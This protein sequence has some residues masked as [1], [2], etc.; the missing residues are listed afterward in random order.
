MRH[1]F[2]LI[3]VIFLSSQS[4]HS[5]L[6]INHPYYPDED[7]NQLIGSPDLL[8]FLSYDGEP[9]TP[10]PIVVDSMDLGSVLTSMQQAI[11]SIQTNVANLQEGL[12][13]FDSASFSNDLYKLVVNV[14]GGSVNSISALYDPSGLNI[15]GVNG[16][17]AVVNSST[18]VAITHPL[19]VPLTNFFSLGINGSIVHTRTFVLN[20]TSVYSVIQNP[21]FT[22]ATI[23][24]V[25]PTHAGYSPPGA[26]NLYTLFFRA[27]Q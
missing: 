7:D 21:T 13:A 10:D 26:G 15:N 8:G 9:F 4:V 6:L 16:W 23:Y 12:N 18:S 11:A 24:G 27:G 14:L 22:T 5:Q 25:Y 1:Y 17:S 2:A 20:N 19:G 3:I